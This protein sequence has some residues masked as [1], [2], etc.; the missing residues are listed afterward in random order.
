MR[1]SKVDGVDPIYSDNLKHATERC[2]QY[3]VFLFNSILSHG[4]IPDSFL[5]ATVI[6]IPKNPRLNVTN[7]CNYRAIAL[8]S[9]FSKVFDKII[10]EKQVWLQT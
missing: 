9:I 3:I 10:T 1:A 4:C 7:S 2:I 8:S 5:F 6:P